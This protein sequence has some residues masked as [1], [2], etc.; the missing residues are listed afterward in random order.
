M[1]A[2]DTSFYLSSLSRPRLCFSLVFYPQ[3]GS[4]HMASGGSSLASALDQHKDDFLPVSSA[5]NQ[6]LALI[7]LPWVNAH[8]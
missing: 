3:T 7:G 1:V 5:S 2:L 8:P 4:L 6:V